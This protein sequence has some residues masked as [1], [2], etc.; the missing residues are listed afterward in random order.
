[1]E[2]TCVGCGAVSECSCPEGTFHNHTEAK[3]FCETCMELLSESVPENQLKDSP[4]RAEA[5]QSIKAKEL[6]EHF[7]VMMTGATFDKL[8]A[9]EKDMLKEMSKKELAQ[10]AMFR[11]M[12]VGFLFHFDELNEK[13]LDEMLKDIDTPEK[14]KQLIEYASKPEEQTESDETLREET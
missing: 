3:Y 13:E 5:N 10:E 8:W 1:M 6:A 11:G 7:S 4:K 2:N 12:R 14:Q 9:E